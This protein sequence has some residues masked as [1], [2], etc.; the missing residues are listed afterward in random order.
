MLVVAHIDKKIRN[1]MRKTHIERRKI[2]LLKHMK[3]RKR[4]KENVIGLAD[5]GSPKLCGDFR[6]GV[7]NTCDEVHGEERG[8]AK[9]IHG[10]GMKM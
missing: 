8:E 5:V 1:V 4:L 2:S 10:G 7:I 6:D 3:I 9:E